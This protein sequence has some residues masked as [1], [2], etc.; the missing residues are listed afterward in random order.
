M[1]V[2]TYIHTHT[3]TCALHGG[4]QTVTV[5]LISLRSVHG[6]HEAHSSDIWL[7]S[8]GEVLRGRRETELGDRQPG[9]DFRFCHHPTGW[10]SV[11]HRISLD[12][13]SPT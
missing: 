4:V 3:L 9:W 5:I 6:I 11:G 8:L 1:W 7:K 12:P 2:C 10:P 13:R